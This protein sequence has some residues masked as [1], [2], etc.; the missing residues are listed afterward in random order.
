PQNLDG[1]NLAPFLKGEKSTSPHDALF[2]SITGSGAV[3]Q[4]Q[5]KLVL[6]PNGKA[7][8]FDLANDLEEKHDLSATEA[9]RVKELTDKWNAWHAQMPPVPPK[10]KAKNEE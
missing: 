5:W 10:G 3:R 2:F 8:L 7:Q 9:N 1:V 4:D 6:A